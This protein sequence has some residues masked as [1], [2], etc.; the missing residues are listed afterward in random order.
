MMKVRS[1]M[2]Y[3]WLAPET[4]GP[5]QS[6]CRI[7]NQYRTETCPQKAAAAPQSFLASTNPTVK[8]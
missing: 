7:L 3:F 5:W 4:D 2:F 8:G 1:S 6:Y